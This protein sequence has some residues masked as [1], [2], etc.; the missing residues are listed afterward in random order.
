VRLFALLALAVRLALHKRPPG[1]GGSGKP[2]DGDGNGPGQPHGADG[3]PAQQHGS[4][5]A[6]EG[7]TSAQTATGEIARQ[8]RPDDSDQESSQP[9]GARQETG[10]QWDNVEGNP[11]NPANIHVSDARRVHIL[12]G[13]G[14][15]VGGGHAPGTGLPNKSEFPERWDDDVIMGH[16]EDVA[17]NPDHPPELQDN[18]RWVVRG[19]RDG[20]DIEVVILPNGLIWSAYPTGGNGVTRNDEHGNPIT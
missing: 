2:H 4:I 3:K 5:N 11:P 19:T 15:G 12:D 14:D 10:T 18:G 6:G 17:R 7:V 13:D 20:V 9:P 8:G 16:V 1:G